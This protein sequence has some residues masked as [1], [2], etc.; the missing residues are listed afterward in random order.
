MNNMV[1]DLK[2]CVELKKKTKTEG[3]LEM[4]SLG[5]RTGTTDTGFT[6]RLQNKKSE[7]LAM[8]I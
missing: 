6:N 7:S 5:M 1:Q 4:K 8:G 2:M 3:I